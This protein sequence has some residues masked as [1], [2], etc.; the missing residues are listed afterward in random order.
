MSASFHNG[1]YAMASEVPAQSSPSAHARV[2][3]PGRDDLRNSSK[4]SAA[5][6]RNQEGV[7]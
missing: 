2:P 6:A 5:E 7:T 4:S 1:P 3:A